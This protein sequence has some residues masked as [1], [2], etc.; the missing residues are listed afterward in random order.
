MILHQDRQQLKKLNTIMQITFISQ[1]LN[2]SYADSIIINQLALETSGRLSVYSLPSNQV[3]ND[4]S[5]AVYTET[6]LEGI[7]NQK[8]ENICT[9]G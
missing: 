4:I 2:R 9:S 1:A 6:D 7:I 5:R 3:S 8:R